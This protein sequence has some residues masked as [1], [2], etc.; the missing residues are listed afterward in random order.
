VLVG[1]QKP[2]LSERKSLWIASRLVGG[3]C[4][5]NA[6]SDTIKLLGVGKFGN[7]LPLVVKSPEE[8]AIFC[9]PHDV[10]EE[11]DTLMYD[12]DK[13]VFECRLAQHDLRGDPGHSPLKNREL[14]IAR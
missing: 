12:R 13:L 11:V 2:I 1:P 4:P 6:K 8:P 5:I 3:G 10:S 9:V 7:N 14:P